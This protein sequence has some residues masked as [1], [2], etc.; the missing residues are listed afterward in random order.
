VD[1]LSLGTEVA[2]WAIKDFSVALRQQITAAARRQDCTVAE[3][4]HGYFQR[5]GIDGQPFAPVNLTPVEPPPRPVEDLCRLA[6]AAARVAETADRM[7]RKLRA[8]LTRGLAEAAR[9][10]VPGSRRQPPSPPPRA[11]AHE[12]SG[13]VPAAAAGTTPGTGPHA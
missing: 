13:A 11:I 5:H 3:W 10:R 6:E 9:V 7:P 8:S 1:T 12:A 2:T 4:L